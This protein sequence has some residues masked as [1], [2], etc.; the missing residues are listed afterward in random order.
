VFV[1]AEQTE[2]ELADFQALFGYLS[3]SLKVCS[4]SYFG[5]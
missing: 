4:I 1:I 3:Q 5:S 2:D